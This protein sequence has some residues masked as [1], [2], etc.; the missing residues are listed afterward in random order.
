MLK[1]QIEALKYANMFLKIQN[2]KKKKLILY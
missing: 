1:Q 2:N